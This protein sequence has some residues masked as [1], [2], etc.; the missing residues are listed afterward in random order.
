MP[1]LIHKLT[2]SCGATKPSI[3]REPVHSSQLRGLDHV[4]LSL[5]GRPNSL[6]ATVPVTDGHISDNTIQGCETGDEEPREDYHVLRRTASEALP[7]PEPTL[8]EEGC[9]NVRVQVS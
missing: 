1:A 2:S 9:S 5:S 8:H 3:A 6:G 4:S 7:G